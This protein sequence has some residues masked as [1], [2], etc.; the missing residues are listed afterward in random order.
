LRRWLRDRPIAAV[1][2][3]AMFEILETQRILDSKAEVVLVPPRSGVLGD[4]IASG[5]TAVVK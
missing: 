5:A 3:R 2:A 4:L 1:I